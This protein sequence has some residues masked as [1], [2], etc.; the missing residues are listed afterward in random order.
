MRRTR[1][2]SLLLLV[3]SAG[4]VTS[5]RPVAEPSAAPDS[6]KGKTY[7]DAESDH[8][9]RLV[10]LEGLAVVRGILVVGP[11]LGGDS[12]DFHE[13]AW[14]REFL[15]LHGFAFL[16]AKDF[17]MTEYKVLQ[18]ALKQFA[19]DTKH[20]ELVEAP[21]AAT[22][23]SAG[24]GFA[25]RLVKE[26]PY[27]VIA[28]VI[29][30]STLQATHFTPAAVHRTVPVCVITGELE[31]GDGLAGRLE[32]ALA[33][34]RPKDALWGWVAAQGVGH[35][36]AGQE[37]LAM[38]ILDAAVRL[39]YPAEGD[40]RKGP[41]KLKPVDH[42]SGWVAD[43]TTWKSGLTKIAA[44]KDFKGDVKKSS[45]L[46]NEDMAFAYRAYSTFD[47]PLKITSPSPMSAQSE[48]RDS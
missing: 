34:H 21:F 17:Y 18:N 28:A 39:R 29:V 42:K 6:R 43:N 31:G 2:I 26:V 10:V 37:M 8:K 36:F 38:P 35:E 27:K 5:A 48:V 47:R 33:E 41:V 9:F 20:P 13:Q 45:W 40:V 14:Y 4:G 11:C 44:A 19:T 46:L 30:C 1:A 15:N 12:R 22:G 23:L 3:I 24:G 32:P 7:D 25:R 16:G